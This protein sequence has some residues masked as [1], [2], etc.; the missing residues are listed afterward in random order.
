MRLSMPLRSTP[1]TLLIAALL[2]PLAGPARAA[3]N[4]PPAKIG[5]QGNIGHGPNPKI[6]DRLIIDKPGIYENYLIDGQ[7]GGSTLVK[8]TADDV[9]LRNCEIRHG[10]H[11]AITVYAKNVVIDSCRIHHV[12]AGSFDQQHDAHGITGRPT[13][14]TVRNC[15]IGLVSGD[16]LQFD[17]G[18]GVW[19]N[20]LI[21]NCT[22]WTG[23]LPADASNFKQGQRPGENA[24]DTKQL[25]SNP[26]SRIT[27][28]S[29]LMYGWNQP[30]QITNLAALNLKDHVQATVEN[31]LFRDN[32]ICFRLRG[33]QGD[34]GGAHVTIDNCAVYDS[35][36]AVRAEANIENLKINRLGI[37]HG[38]R[39]KLQIAGGRPG[40]GY[41]NTH[42][43]TPPPYEMA[44][45]SG[46]SF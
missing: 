10:Q 1:C 46:L 28:K 25:A 16:C 34:R 8:I 44:L 36:V 43:Y 9:T 6:V 26:R 24:I 39:Q 20:V 19:D 17:P 21:E 31:C 23:P 41:E 37:G 32:E 30:G 7:W 35:A 18:R 33:G 5:T 11:N 15:D 42:E 4:P 29:C 45:Q 40:P 14:L 3:E 12:L 38:I 27:I 22:L 13:N 2:C